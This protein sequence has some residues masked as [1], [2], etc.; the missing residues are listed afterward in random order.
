MARSAL[1]TTEWLAAHL[2]GPALKVVDASW[3]LPTEGRNPAAEFEAAH[4]PGAVFFDIDEIADT[5]SALPHMLPKP[6]QF[7]EWMGA[8]GFSNNDRIVVYDG[9]GLFSAPRVWWTF[10]VFGHDDIAVLSGG[11][12]KWKAEGRPLESG[13]VSPKPGV[14]HARLRRELVRDIGQVRDNIERRSDQVIDARSAGRFEG[15]DPEPR[16]GLRSGHVPGSLNL[17]YGELVDTATGGLLPADRLRARFADAGANLDRPIVTTCGSGVTAS[18]L[19]LALYQL[20]HDTVA[21]YDGSWTEWGGRDDTPI[22]GGH[23]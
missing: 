11:V 18:L 6:E 15:T 19:A 8:L 23:R 20:G 3:Y 21:V 4:I 17:P 12:A 7:G 22:E 1:V 9:P 10:R 13:A 2:G 5:S 14:F 16:P